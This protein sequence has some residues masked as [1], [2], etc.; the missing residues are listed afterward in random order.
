MTTPLLSPSPRLGVAQRPLTRSTTSALLGGVCAGLAVRLGVRE[1]SVR[2]LAVVASL[3]YGVGILLYVTAWVFVP[4]WG[5][6]Q[7]I[8][9]RL[10][11]SR[12]HANHVVGG[13]LAALILLLFLGDFAR[14]GTGTLLWPTLLG[15]AALVAVGTG[16]SREEKEH[17]NDVVSAAPIVGA[18]SARGWRAFTL[19][20]VPGIVL[21]VIGLRVL[22]R[23]GGIWG[24]AV[25]AIIGAGVLALGVAVLLAPWWLDNVRDLSRERRERVH[26]EERA[27]IAAHVHDSVLQTLTLIEKSADHPHDVVRLARAQERELRQWLFVPESARQR[28]ES[29]N[30]FA[31]QL[32]RVQGAVEDDYGVLVELVVVGDCSGDAGVATLCAATR[33]AVVNA[34][35]WASVARVSVYAEVEPATLSV[36]VRDTGVGFDPSLVGADRRGISQSITGR[37]RDAGGEAVIHS[38]PGAGTEVRLTMPRGS[39]TSSDPSPR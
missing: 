30:T 19:R 33:E 18:A 15:G 37:L 36:Y 11:R 34:A 13:F 2:L 16:A 7:S 10:T 23:I 1:R 5:E 8:A 29:D 24:A 32:R 39:T 9:Q 22:S 31:R 26:A 12:T 35:K 27:K 21:A 38:A 17:L 25:P 6:E 28:E 4:R 20:V 3:F 14:H